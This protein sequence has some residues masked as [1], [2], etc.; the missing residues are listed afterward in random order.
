M[1]VP[2][3]T[4]R[5]A[6]TTLSIGETTE[7]T[8]TFSE[9]VTGFTNADLTIPNGTLT[10]VISGDG[11]VIWTATFTPSASVT[12]ATNHITLDNTGVSASGTPGVGTT[13]SDNYVID[14]RRPTATI[15]LAHSNLLADETSLVTVEFS[16]AVAGF[17]NADLTVANGT[18][19][20]VSTD[21][22]GLT[23]TAIFTPSEGI[24]SASN[25]IT[26]ANTGVADLAGNTGSGTTNSNN[27][28]IDTVR[29]TA[30]IWVADNALTIGETSGVTI[31]FSE[32]VAGFSNADLSIANGTLSGVGS[33]DGGITWTAT[34]TPSNAITNTANFITLDNSGVNNAAGNA[35]S[36]TTNSNDYAIDTVRPTATIVVADNALSTGETSTVAFTFSEAVNGFTLADLTVSN[37]TLSGLTAVDAG[38]TWTATFTPAAGISDSSNIITL[39][40]TGVTDLAGNAGSGTTDSN[41]YALDHIRPTAAIALDKAS[42][43]AG[44]TATVTITFSEAV[45]D[46]DLTDLTPAFGALSDLA[47]TNDIVWTATFTPTARI[48]EAAN[49]MSLNMAGVKDKAGNSGIGPVQSVSYALNTMN[50]T[51]TI[52]VADTTLTAG[53]TSLVTITFSE[54]VSGFSNEDLTIEGGVLSIVNSSDGGVTWT[55]RL[56]P[57]ANLSDTTNLITLDN[58]G[59]MSAGNFA[60]IGTT[61]SNNYAVSTP[62]PEPEPNTPTAGDDVI[63]LPAAGGTISAGAGDDSVAGGGGGDFVH[64]N[65]GDDSLVGGGGDDIVRGGQGADFVQGNTGDDL[66]FGDLGDDTAVGGQGSDFVQGAAGDDYVAGDLGNDT[67]LGGQ[68]DDRVL[69]GAGDDYVSGDL[70]NDTLTGGTGAD[71]FNFSGGA[72]RD[73]VTDF[74]RA[75][76]DQIRISPSDAANFSALSSHIASQ[77]EDTLITLGAQTVVL[78]GVS[79]GSLTAADFVFA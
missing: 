2:T 59:V 74:S 14:T 40:N 13:D 73:V 51:A 79:A 32:A 28:A 71:L 67:V 20:A 69:G 36:G 6:D 33:S 9:A 68:G 56:T 49:T 66:I 18:L 29:P 41:N 8:F 43:I 1:P 3:A 52:V 38:V 7:V 45:R 42:L 26:L 22:G 60:G 27:Y 12:D 58:T 10:S 75:Q 57:S 34:F 17:T 24:N 25:V 62:A 48:L 54:A 65:T 44:E 5:F 63:T 39:D 77:G 61:H 31:T 30:T 46:F 53:E 64:G 4:I 70:G 72:G 21:N 23:F 37:G 78:V 76:G 47:T 11:G 15:T 35:G 16:E 19:S 50:P 55:G